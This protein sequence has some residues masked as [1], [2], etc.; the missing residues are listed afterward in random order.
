MKIL[1]VDDDADLLKAQARLL[2]Y[3]GFQVLQAGSG[4]RAL[5]L[6][7]AEKPELVLLDVIMPEMGGVEVCQSIKNDP[8]LRNTFVVLLSSVSKSSDEQAAGLE[9]GADDFI[10]R[11]VPSRELVARL[12]ALLR[13][14]QTEDALRIALA[15][16]ELLIKEIH[17]LVKNNLEII[18]SLA[19]LQSRRI[20]DPAAKQ[21]L[22]E[23]QDR[24]RTIILVY[25]SLHRSDNV[26]Q[27]A[28][29]P[30]F[31]K[32]TDDLI[33][34]LGAQLFHL[35]RDFD[36][37]DLQVKQAVPIGLILNELVTNAVKYAFPQPFQ[38]RE[39]V[40]GQ[41]EP[42]IRLSL[43]R[44]A[45]QKVLE[46]SDNGVGMPPGYDWKNARSLGLRLVNLLSEQLHGQLEAW[47]EN[48]TRF[49]LTFI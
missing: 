18:L 15:E 16:K 41:P 48:G 8:D 39:N 13:I 7:R 38:L 1:V 49:R 25:E 28:A 40:G 3:E 19:D 26:T 29:R 6:I 34:A 2:E 36:D 11:P 17:H 22:Q 24:V 35:E 5:E 44:Q 31:E 20:E 23:L 42:T 14:K 30:F 9:A 46:V 4:R 47:V 43:K 45:D 21:S 12:Q 37:I 10:T 32:L 27:V 33:N